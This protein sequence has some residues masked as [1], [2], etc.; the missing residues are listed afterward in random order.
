MIREITKDEIAECVKVIK[1]SFQ[2]VAKE[3]NITLENAP[4]Y[5]AFSTT[6]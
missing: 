5:V 2:T 6:E 4:R 3:F 1:A